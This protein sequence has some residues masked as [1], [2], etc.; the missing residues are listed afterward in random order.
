VT[1]VWLGRLALALAGISTV[2]AAAAGLW[3][4]RTGDVRWRE[5]ARGAAVGTAV[6]LTAAVMALEV[7]L[8]GGDF[9]VWAV[10]NH[11]NR[12]LPLA[13]RMTALWGGDSGSV[14]FWG[15]ILSLY[16]A[17]VAGIGWRKERRMTPLVVPML[18]GLLVFFTGMSNLVVDPFRVV[19]GSPTDGNGLDPLLQNPVMTIHPPAMYTGLIGLAVPFAFY[20]A[21]LW[22]RLPG[23]VWTPV[24]RR[25][26]LWSWMF[27]SAAIV[28]G[29]WWAY[30]ELGWGGYWEWDPVENASL[31]PWLT[32]T[33]FLHTLQVEDRRGMFRAVGA[34]LITATFLLT[35]VGTY[36]T[37]SGVLPN[38][39]HAFTGT[40]VGNYFF[41]LLWAVLAGTVVVLVLRRDQLV[42]RI[43]LVDTF[44]REGVYFLMSFFLAVLAAVVLF[45][46]FYPVLSR[47]LTGT[48]VVLQVGFFNTLSVPL[49]LGLVVL[50][51]AAPAVAWRSARWRQTARRLSGAWMAAIAG[52]VLAYGWGART[53]AQLLGDTVVF[54]AAGSMIQEFVRGTRARQRSTREPWPQALWG[55]VRADRRRWGGYLSHLAFLVIVLGV[56]GSHTGNY[57][58]TETFRP[59]QTEAV[60][61]YRVTF[62]GLT[63]VPGPT[64]ETT[65]AAIVVNGPGYRNATAT[66]GLQFFPG[67]AQPVAHVA[68]LG[69]WWQDF[70]AV[71]EGYTP[72]GQTVNLQFFV[73]PMVSWIWIGMY[74][75]VAGSLVALG[76]PERPR[77]AVRAGAGWLPLPAPLRE[78]R[79]EA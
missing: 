79:D 76:G 7:A 3:A 64:Y 73:N 8:V 53:P 78:R 59:G 5:S 72:G 54:F 23:R 29:G 63:D 9:S 51:G 30:M 32:A 13:Y 75:L 19:P 47:A 16:T 70:Y 46:T 25:W 66:P 48:A 31:L 68:I 14:L 18:A 69:G 77:S 52:V 57:T 4:H 22:Q 1:M 43:P 28:L 12:G 34:A 24:V 62:T 15:W 71:L 74:L 21:A 39:V 40:G 44:S 33:A 11:T 49:F 26:L 61:P 58:V 65:Q 10:Y 36:I 37:R 6:A 42:D 20:L 2:Y 50:M 38:S 55:L 56:I 17:Y 41:G 67:N 27:L 60:G 45:G 35:L